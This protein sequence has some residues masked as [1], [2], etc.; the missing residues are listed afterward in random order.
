MEIELHAEKY[1]IRRGEEYFQCFA[2]DAALWIATPYL[3]HHF[4]VKGDA[5][6]ARAEIRRRRRKAKARWRKA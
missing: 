5:E 2:A 6:S 4:A 3:A 1:V